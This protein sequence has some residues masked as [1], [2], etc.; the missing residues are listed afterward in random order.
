MN[1]LP[2][3]FATTALALLVASCGSGSDADPVPT[4]AASSGHA[5][6]DA[7][8][9]FAAAEMAMND[10]M[11]TAI[12]A[13]VSDTWVAQMI[14]HHR[15]AI[16]MSNIVLGQNPTSDVRTMAEQ[17]ISKQGKEIADLTRLRGKSPANP[18]SLEPYR[19]A[20]MAMHQ[21]MMSAK[22][23]NISETYLRK[24]LEHHRGAVALSDVVIAQGIDSRVRAIAQKTRADQAREATMLEAMLAGQPMSTSSSA[25]APVAKPASTMPTASPSSVPK[26]TPVT[27]SNPKPTPSNTTP[28]PTTSPAAPGPKAGHDMKDM[29]GMK[30]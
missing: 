23:A 18:A 12:G 21:A 3:L 11:M 25:P 8:S 30:M 22:G 14:E 28:A 24:M 4:A 10:K 9:P 16:A 19:P 27:S 26:R 13:N 7:G 2:Q 17:T 15:G 20:G 29:P 5:M 1:K 6:S